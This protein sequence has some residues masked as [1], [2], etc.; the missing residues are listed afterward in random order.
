MPLHWQPDRKKSGVK[1][2]STRS[3]VKRMRSCGRK[4]IWS[5]WEWAG[6]SR[7][8]T[9]LS[10]RSSSFSPGRFHLGWQGKP[11][12]RMGRLLAFVGERGPESC[13]HINAD[14]LPDWH[15]EWSLHGLWRLEP[16]SYV[17]GAW[18][19]MNQRGLPWANSCAFWRMLF[20]FSSPNPLSTTRTASSPMIKPTLG[21]R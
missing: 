20:P 8:R 6:N 17:L 9:R 4:M 14:R 2:A 19:L 15:S 13:S 12:L 10:P 11:L 16:R 7:K 3:P 18:V 1:W 21:T 5:P